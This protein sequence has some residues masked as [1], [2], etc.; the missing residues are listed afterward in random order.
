MLQV[1]PSQAEIA[2]M[3]KANEME[4]NRPGRFF[5]SRR[6]GVLKTVKLTVVND[7]LVV[8]GRELLDM[9]S[10]EILTMK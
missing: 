7:M 2:N 9:D 4:S 6:N 8:D 5:I 1:V 10:I 3:I